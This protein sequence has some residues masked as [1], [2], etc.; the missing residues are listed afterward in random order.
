MLRSTIVAIAWLEASPDWDVLVDK[1]DRA[2][3]SIPLFRM[4][5]SEPPG[6]RGH[7]ALVDRPRFRSRRGTSGA[8]MRPRRTPP[9]PV[10]DVARRAATTAFDPAHPLWEF[11]LVE[12][13][14]GD[15]AALVMKVHHSLTDGVGGM[16]WRC[17][18][19]T[20]RPAP[21]LPGPMPDA[22]T[23][24]RPTPSELLRDSLRHDGGRVLAFARHEALV[25]PPCRDPRRAVIRCAPRPPS[26]RRRSRSAARSRPCS[27]TMSPVMTERSLGRDLDMVTVR[28]ADLKR[29]AAVGGRLGE[30]RLH[31]RSHWW[32]PPLPRLPRTDR[33]RTCG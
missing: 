24:S 16:N 25:A 6:A 1:I 18:S 13:L 17:S 28:L 2:S 32:A 3:R 30:R 22:P 10:I 27:D 12:H 20:S 29:A 14:E 26:W 15:R 8:S 23:G 5:V 19:S 7:T 9:P 33:R 21:R 31:R 11:T 4:R